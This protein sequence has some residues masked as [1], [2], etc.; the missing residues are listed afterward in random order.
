MNNI[1][2]KQFLKEIKSKYPKITIHDLDEMS[3]KINNTKN[4]VNLN[5]KI[6]NNQIKKGDKRDNDIAKKCAIEIRNTWKKELTTKIN[7]MSTKNNNII[8]LGLSTYSKNHKIKVKIDTKNKFFINP[9]KNTEKIIEFNLDNYRKNIIDGTFPLKYIDNEYLTKQREKIKK[10]YFNLGYKSKSY[11]GVN[12]WIYTK[13]HISD[14]SSEYLTS[15]TQTISGGSLFVGSKNSYNNVIKSRK[16]QR[17]SKRKILNFMNKNPNSEYHGYRQKWLA[18]LSSISDINKYIR[19]GFIKHNK[20]LVPF[21]Q[22]K[23]GGAFSEL[24]KGCYL[25]KASESDFD[26][27]DTKYKGD[28][29]SNVNIKSKQYI[30]NIYNEIMKS[31]VKLFK[32]KS[33]VKI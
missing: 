22:E 23:Y 18:L 32:Y 1:T 16:I 12:N 11:N 14:R 6:I 20:L 19:K 27:S 26:L 4:I 33:R 17:R 28:P 10:I 15:D 25:Y 21:V 29:V 8:L 9:K 24:Q 30:D 2:R 31:G 5:K 13:F 3:H 7:K